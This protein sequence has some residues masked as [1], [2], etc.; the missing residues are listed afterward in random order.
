MISLL[1]QKTMY[2]KRP[3]EAF[4]MVIWRAT[5]VQHKNTFYITKFIYGY[6]FS[7]H[8]YLVPYPCPVGFY[9]LIST[10]LATST[11]CPIGTFAPN[12]KTESLADCTSCTAGSFCATP[13]LSA[14]TAECD[15][16]Y[17]CTL[18][19]ETA[20]PVNH[21]VKIT[22][23]YADTSKYFTWLNYIYMY[24]YNIYTHKHIC[25]VCLCNVDKAKK[26][27]TGNILIPW[28]PILR[29]KKQLA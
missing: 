10:G 17:Y 3:F 13:G 26:K 18:A 9:C 19:A 24:T 2:M 21:L 11:P 7:G 27:A 14:P 6:Q 16:G 28:R 25:N 23:M 1:D 20:T 29:L 4:K 5:W 12:E 15:G 22:F 8:T